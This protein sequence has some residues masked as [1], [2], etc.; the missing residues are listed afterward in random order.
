[1]ELLFKEGVFLVKEL[2]TCEEREAAFRLRHDVFCDEL[3]WVPPSPEQMEEYAYDAFAHPIGLFDVRNQLVGH[4]RLIHAPRPF[5]IEKE[6]SCLVPQDRA[7]RKTM[8]TAEVTRLCVKKETRRAG[9]NTFNVSQLLYKGVYQWSLYN[10]VRFLVMV[11]EKKYYRLL[12]LNSFPVK[13]ADGFLSMGAGVKAGIITL[14]WRNFE[15]ENEDKNP[16]LIEWMSKI[17]IYAPLQLLQLE[18]CSRHPASSQYSV[19]GI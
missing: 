3:K 14:D 13:A 5:M 15:E 12:R 18:P 16:D 19:R 2:T 11:V 8:D 4:V 17:S 6:F 9:S 1:M 7:I 10:E